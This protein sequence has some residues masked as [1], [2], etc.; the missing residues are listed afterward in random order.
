MYAD[1][2][3]KVYASKHKLVDNDTGIT[4]HSQGYAYGDLHILF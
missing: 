3:S 1:F 2:L 4:N